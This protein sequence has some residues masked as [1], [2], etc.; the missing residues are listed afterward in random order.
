MLT[1]PGCETTSV[2]FIVSATFTAFVTFTFVVFFV[3]FAA[4]GGGDADGRS[5]L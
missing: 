3:S 2:D 5:C 4:L 1:E